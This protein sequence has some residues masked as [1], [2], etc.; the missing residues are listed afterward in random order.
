MSILCYHVA[1]GQLQYNIREQDEQNI[2]RNE[3]SGELNSCGL[4]H[5]NRTE[6]G[7]TLGLLR[8]LRWVILLSY[9]RKVS[10]VVIFFVVVCY[11]E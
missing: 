6:F 4:G 10:V 2:L 5:V 9:Q 7:H 3:H 8:C 11:I 1:S